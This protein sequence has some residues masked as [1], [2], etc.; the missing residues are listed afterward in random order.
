MSERAAA[1]GCT[2]NPQGVAFG[3]YDSVSGAAVDGVGYINL[4]CDSPTSLE[5]RLSAGASG[6]Y[7]ARAM[8]ASGAE[9]HYNLYSDVGRTAVWGDGVG[10]T[11]TVSTTVSVE[12]D[13]TVYGR[14]APGQNLPAG[15]YSD[16]IVVTVVY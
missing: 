2:V 1:F 13:V 6:S 12:Q 8:S 11:A 14:I 15:T 4:A 10:G 3:T 16:M 7:A 5:V 9:M